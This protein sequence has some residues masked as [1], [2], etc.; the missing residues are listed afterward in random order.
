MRHAWIA[1][2][3]D[4]NHRVTGLQV[5]DTYNFRIR[6]D[7]ADGTASAYSSQSITLPGPSATISMCNQDSRFFREDRRI[8]CHPPVPPHSPF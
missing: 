5:G 4:C 8:Q 3:S 1:K 2:T 6:A 7:Y